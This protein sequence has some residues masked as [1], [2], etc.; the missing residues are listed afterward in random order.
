VYKVFSPPA[1]G[2]ALAFVKNQVTPHAILV[3]SGPEQALDQSSVVAHA[4][5]PIFY[6]HLVANEKLRS[7]RDQDHTSK[8]FAN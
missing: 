6:T 3:W 8:I 2:N 1:L 5:W 4:G 7:A